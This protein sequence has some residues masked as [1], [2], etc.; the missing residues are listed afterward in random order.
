MKGNIVLYGL[1]GPDQQYRALKYF[2]IA[3]GEEVSI[4]DL[5]FR[6]LFMKQTFPGIKKV[7]A[8]DNRPGLKKDYIDSYRINTIESCAIFKDLLEREGIL[9]D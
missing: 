2:A 9:I 3:E 7:Y 4:L 6:A 5:K 8:I 1:S